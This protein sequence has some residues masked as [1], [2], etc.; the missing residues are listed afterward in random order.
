MTPVSPVLPGTEIRE[1]VI[2]KD[3]PEYLPLPAVVLD[4]A[5]GMPV[6]TRWRL[7]DEERELVKFGHDIVLT[8]M[9]FGGPLQPVHLQVVHQ[10]D[11]PTVDH[12]GGPR[13]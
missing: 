13:S 1:V 7:T 9:T 8:Q 2:A 3:Q 10:N 4:K 11:V 6:M 12:L 5:P